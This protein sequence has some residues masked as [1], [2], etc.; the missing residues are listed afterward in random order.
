MLVKEKIAI[1]LTSG[2]RRCRMHAWGL[3]KSSK[4]PK[5]VQEMLVRRVFKTGGSL[6]MVLPPQLA[7]TLGVSLGDYVRLSV[8]KDHSLRVE[9]EEEARKEG[10]AG[11]K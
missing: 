9:A 11:D 4:D 10:S 5:E 2:S 8:N 7:E 1:I 3:K 6:C